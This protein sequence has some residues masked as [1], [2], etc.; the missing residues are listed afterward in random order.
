MVDQRTPANRVAVEENASANRGVEEPNAPTARR[1]FAGPVRVNKR[2]PTVVPVDKKLLREHCHEVLKLQNEFYMQ[3]IYVKFNLDMLK[4]TNDEWLQR[5]G[6]YAGT[7]EETIY[8]AT[9][10]DINCI[11]NRVFTMPQSVGDRLDVR[12]LIGCMVYAINKCD[13]GYLEMLY[14]LRHGNERAIFD[15]LLSEGRRRVTQANIDNA[16]GMDG[17]SLAMKYAQNAVLFHFLKNVQFQEQPQM[18]T[19]Y[20]P[21]T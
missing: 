4:D 19:I 8:N 7:L 14:T 1:V 15:V 17:D 6:A 10:I 9:H 18:T 16:N 21:R 3:E 20:P 5:S 12:E 2:N 11:Q 13:V